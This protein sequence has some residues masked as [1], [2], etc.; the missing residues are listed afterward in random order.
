LNTSPIQFGLSLLFV[1]DDLSLEVCQT[2]VKA[3]VQ[4]LELDAS[5]LHS[6]DNLTAFSMM[7]RLQKLFPRSIHACFGKANDYDFSQ[8]DEKGCREA[9]NTA[10][11]AVNIAVGLDA[12][13]IVMHLSVPPVLPT[14][15]ARRRQRCLL[16]LS[17]IGQA[18]AVNGR[19]IALEN[20]PGS[21]LGN[22]I[23]ELD[24][25]LDRLGDETFG[26]C[27]DVNHLEDRYAE[28]PDIVRSIGP[29]LAALHVSD[30][31]GLEEKHWKPGKGVVDWPSLMKALAEIHYSGPF[32]FECSGDGDDLAAKIADLGLT[33]NWLS[34]LA[35]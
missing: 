8:L 23:D 2:M 10:F 33:Y 26:I 11:E 34:G 24:W 27:L 4:A 6:E 15:R 29:R 7:L 12:G 21:N 16:S 30:Y 14:E 17:E 32:T 20:L 1:E 19:R 3:G 18:A 35:Q 13:V 28:L 5:C 22:D 31:D 9:I 25:F